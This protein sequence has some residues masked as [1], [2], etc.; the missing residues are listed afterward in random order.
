MMKELHL[1]ANN[2]SRKMPASKKDRKCTHC[3]GTGH[4]VETCFQLHG[5]P[6]WHPKGK[7]V[8]Y[9]SS[10]AKELD[11]KGNLATTL[12]FT[13]KSGMSFTSNSDWIID[14]GATDHMTCDRYRFSHL[15]PKCSKTTIT[16][17]NGVSSPVIGVGTVPLSPTLAIKD[18]YDGNNVAVSFD[19]STEVFCVTPL[20]KMY[21]TSPRERDYT[22]FDVWLMK[23]NEY[24]YD[25]KESSST[26]WSHEFTVEPPPRGSCSSLGFSNESE[27]FILQSECH[28][29]PFLYDP[30]TKQAREVPPITGKPN[31]IYAESLVSVKG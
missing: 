24:N 20:P 3:N 23:D 9:V 22:W 11:S 26:W 29:A 12:G 30:L 13:A 31:F 15:S 4:T 21:N 14:S 2:A 1:A 18:D 7:K 17:A 27:L 19:M 16:N 10:N 28:G 6:D 8:S 25:V 5:Y